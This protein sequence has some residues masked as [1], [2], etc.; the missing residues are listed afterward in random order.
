MRPKSLRA[1]NQHTSRFTSQP[2]TLLLIAFYKTHSPTL[3]IRFKAIW[4]TVF[5]INTGF[6]PDNESASQ[7]PLIVDCK[8]G[9][10]QTHKHDV[11][12]HKNKLLFFLIKKNTTEKLH[13]L[14]WYNNKVFKTEGSY[15]VKMWS[16]NQPTFRKDDCSLPRCAF[17]FGKEVPLHVVFLIT[18]R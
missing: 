15:S 5:V 10:L 2:D 7:G 13:S 6:T 17:G 11:N 4:C 16:P 3:L 8:D 14:L 12:Q 18:D 1:F 9:L